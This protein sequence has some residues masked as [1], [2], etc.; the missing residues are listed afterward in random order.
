MLD[1]VLEYPDKSIN[2]QIDVGDDNSENGSEG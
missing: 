2:G 1:F